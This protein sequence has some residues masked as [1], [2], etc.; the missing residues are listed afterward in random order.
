[1]AVISR[2]TRSEQIDDIFVSTYQKAEKAIQ[3]QVFDPQNSA[4]WA[5]LR[6]SDGLR[7][8]LGGDF[9][10]F[11]VEIG[12]N[13]NI[14]ALAKGGTVDLQVLRMM[15]QHLIKSLQKKVAQLVEAYT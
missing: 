8:Q 13:D 14:Q 6:A 9:I 1:M 15:V 5:M 4:L 12:Q 11:D 2:R 3:D 7:A 10:K